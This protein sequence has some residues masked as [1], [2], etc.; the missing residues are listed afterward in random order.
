MR[1]CYLPLPK[2][3]RAA[4]KL[5]PYSVTTVVGVIYVV[6][7]NLFTSRQV[8]ASQNTGGKTH[9]SRQQQSDATM[10]IEFEDV[11]VRRQTVAHPA[12]GLRR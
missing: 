10:E 2:K 12:A 9:N 4:W 5:S 6:T 3:R 11:L 8:Q 7:A 1:N